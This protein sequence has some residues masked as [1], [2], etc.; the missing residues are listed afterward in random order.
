MR[1]GYFTGCAGNLIYTNVAKSVVDVL[2]AYGY[3]VVIP[4]KQKCNGTPA[5][6]FSTTTYTLAV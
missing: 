6:D 1:I 3:E 2:T 5:D 4:K